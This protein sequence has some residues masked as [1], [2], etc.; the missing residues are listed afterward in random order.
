MG[1][2]RGKITVTREFSAGSVTGFC[3][4]TAEAPGSILGRG[5]NTSQATR[6]SQKKKN[7][8]HEMMVT[9]VQKT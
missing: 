4:F 8:N 6:H 2:Q 5:T 7:Y 9:Y 3:P 1:Q